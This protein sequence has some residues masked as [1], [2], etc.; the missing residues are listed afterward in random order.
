MIRKSK[1]LLAVSS[2]ASIILISQV[3]FA[4]SI[5]IVNPSFEIPSVLFET[6]GY[7]GS[8]AITGWTISG[9]G[10]AGVWNPSEYPPAV[11][12]APVGVQVGYIDGS[13]TPPYST[14]SVP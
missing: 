2:L 14:A 12:T 8:S 4:G 7:A 1:H 6:L 13:R 9:P 5:G 10:Q 11:L 3:T